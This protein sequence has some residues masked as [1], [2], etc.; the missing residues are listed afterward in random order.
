VRRAGTTSASSLLLSQLV[1]YNT[2][3]SLIQ[4][5][6]GVGVIAYKVRAGRARSHG[7]GWA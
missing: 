6:F 2:W 4:V 3:F 5:F 1:Y 7:D